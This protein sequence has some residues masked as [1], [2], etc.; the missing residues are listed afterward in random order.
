MP[1]FNIVCRAAITF[2]IEASS[3]AAAEGRK[4]LPKK[5]SEG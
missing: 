4:N 3:P 5:V 1:R 2:P